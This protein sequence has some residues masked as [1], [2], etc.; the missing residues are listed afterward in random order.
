MHAAPGEQGAADGAAAASAGD[1]ATTKPKSAALKYAG[2]TTLGVG[3]VGLGVGG[4]FLGLGASKRGD[5]TAAYDACGGPACVQGSAG[6]LNAQKLDNDA[7]TLETVG[8]IGLIA[9]GVLA[10][11][12]V[13]MLL[14]APRS[15]APATSAQITP[16]FGPGSAGLRGTF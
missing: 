9:G 4:V 3:V 2:W 8:T 14:L 1:A 5:A 16:W 10:G 15:S 7:T 13:T 12:G 6:A 11:A